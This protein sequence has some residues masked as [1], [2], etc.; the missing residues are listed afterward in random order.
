[1]TK[2]EAWE[3]YRTALGRYAEAYVRAGEVVADER[4]SH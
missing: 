3:N 2:D 1:M 4:E